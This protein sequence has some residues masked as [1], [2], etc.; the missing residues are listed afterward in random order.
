MSTDLL[1]LLVDKLIEEKNLQILEKA[2]LLIKNLLYGDTGTY[3]ALSTMIIARLSELLDHQETAVF[4]LDL[5][6]LLLFLKF[7]ADP[8][9]C[10]TSA[11]V[12]EL[13]GSRKSEN[14]C[15]RLRFAALRAFKR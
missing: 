9:T 4:Y 7:S 6:E 5:R 3:K 2:L 13:L 14:Y 1:F 11:R 8:R 12:P 15:G 10:D